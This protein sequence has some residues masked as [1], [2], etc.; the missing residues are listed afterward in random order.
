MQARMESRKSNRRP[1]LQCS[2]QRNFRRLR[3][4]PLR[5]AMEAKASSAFGIE[6]FSAGSW[7][8]PSFFNHK[9]KASGNAAA[10]FFWNKS[11]AYDAE[12]F[13]V[14]FLNV[15]NPADV[16]T[17][18]KR[19]RAGKHGIRGVAHAAAHRFLGRMSRPGCCCH[20]ESSSEHLFHYNSPSG[21]DKICASCLLTKYAKNPYGARG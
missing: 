13:F 14:D 9:E 3:Q 21:L 20:D 16:V 19:V 5:P 10:S 8:S 4:M 15:L 1:A 6:A 7:P 11:A 12:A 17:V 2:R 18:E